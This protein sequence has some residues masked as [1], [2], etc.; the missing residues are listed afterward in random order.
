AASSSGRPVAWR[1]TSGWW[2][3]GPA[4]RARR[5]R[6]RPGSE[7]PPC[8][9]PHAER[10]DS[11]RDGARSLHRYPLTSVPAV[12]WASLN[13]SGTWL[14]PHTCTRFAVKVAVAGLNVG[15]LKK[16]LAA[17]TTPT[18]SPTWSEPSVIRRSCLPRRYTVVAFTW[19]GTS[20][21]RRTVSYG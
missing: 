13:G 18:P 15:D 14:R 17:N 1:N 11:G 20:W 8:P 3:G 7:Q 6:A 5:R 19:I 4:T 9:T 2:I 12:C 10:W 21:P 16:P